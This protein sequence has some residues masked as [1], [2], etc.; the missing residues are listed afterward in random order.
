MRLLLEDSDGQGK[1]QK[2]A[3]EDTSAHLGDCALEKVLL[4][5]DD[6]FIGADHA[7]VFDAYPLLEKIVA[8]HEN[9]AALV[10][11]VKRR[12]DVFFE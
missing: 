5:I 11:E 1:F 7:A 10:V 8:F 12:C 4:N 3:L 6:S 9:F 2:L